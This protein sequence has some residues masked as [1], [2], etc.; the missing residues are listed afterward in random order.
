MAETKL[1][2]VTI[3]KTKTIT[4]KLIPV[5]IKDIHWQI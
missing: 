3:K 5:C 4:K 1:F 2:D